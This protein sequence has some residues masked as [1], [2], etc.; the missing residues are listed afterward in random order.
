[1]IFLLPE[2]SGTMVVE[3]RFYLSKHTPG[4]GERC[5]GFVKKA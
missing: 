3:R 4:R 5:Q 1:M 2:R